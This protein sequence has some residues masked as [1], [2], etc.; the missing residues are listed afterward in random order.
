LSD[1]PDNGVVFSYRTVSHPEVTPC[2]CA[3]PGT[4]MMMERVGG[5]D[6][7]RCWCGRTARMTFDDAEDR[8]EFVASQT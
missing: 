5:V 3:D 7:L 1:E 8:R 6:Y 2:P 4:F